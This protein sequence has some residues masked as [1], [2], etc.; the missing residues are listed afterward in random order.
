MEQNIKD[1]NI[2]NNLFFIDRR[3]TFANQINAEKKI[4]FEIPPIKTKYVYYVLF[5]LFF[6]FGLFLKP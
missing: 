5:Q 6:N 2:E 1:G 3:K 4:F